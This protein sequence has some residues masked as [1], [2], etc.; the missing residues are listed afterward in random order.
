MPQPEI[1]YILKKSNTFLLFPTKQNE[2]AS[3]EY[4]NLLKF[5]NIEFA[6]WMKE[7]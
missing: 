4:S 2:S 5:T 6:L 3:L 7:T 1:I